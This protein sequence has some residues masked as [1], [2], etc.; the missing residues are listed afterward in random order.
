MTQHNGVPAGIDRR[1]PQASD[2]LQW[3]QARN[4]E[5]PSPRDPRI[6]ADDAFAAAFNSTMYQPPPAQ[7]ATRSA[8]HLA[9]AV[10]SAP[11]PKRVPRPR[12]N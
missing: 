3:L 2:M 11:L 6:D 8:I 1:S 9:Q 10:A 4:S 12:P 7:P 5:T